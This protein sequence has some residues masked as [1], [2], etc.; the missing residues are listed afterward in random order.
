MIER[1]TY[2]ARELRAV[3]NDGKK[4]LMGYAAVFGQLS[5]DLGGF[6]E[7]VAPGAFAATVAEDDIRA[8]WNHEPGE[9]LGRNKAGT[10]ALAEDQQGLAIEIDPPDTQRGRDAMVSI[11]RGDVSQMSFGFQTVTDDWNY[12]EGEI[13]RTL[14]KVRLFDVS[15]VTF[16]AYP[17]TDISI[18]AIDPVALAR[19][20]SMRRDWKAYAEAL[21]AQAAAGRP[22]GS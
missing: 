3:E 12:R 2:P 17:Q 6:R 15:P 22:S 10:L 8:L 5:E 1:R 11:G 9:I 16:P 13:I 18:R 14:V 20:A 19:A 7:Q 21:N 4:K